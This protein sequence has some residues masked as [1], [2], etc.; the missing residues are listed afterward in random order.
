MSQD[1][2]AQADCRCL[3]HLQITTTLLIKWTNHYLQSIL[4][5]LARLRETAVLG[6]TE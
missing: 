6:K 2:P 5:C 3:Q 4:L 1:H